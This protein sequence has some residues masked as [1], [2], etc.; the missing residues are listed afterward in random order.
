[1]N[2]YLDIDGV[3]LTKD[4]KPANHLKEFLE[5]ITGNHEVYWLTTHYK[6]D[7]ETTLTYLSRFLGKDIIELLQRVKP[8]NWGTLKTDAIDFNKDF[9]W[10]DD[11]ILPTER[12]V[13]E[14]RNK[15]DSWIEVK[16]ESNGDGLLHSLERL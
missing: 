3:I 7:S 14:Q 11:Y 13:L 9:V 1:M 15:L 8:T 4:L 2:I 16:I 10:L 5:R 6:G 12:S